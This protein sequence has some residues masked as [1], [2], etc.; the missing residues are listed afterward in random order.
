MTVGLQHYL[1]VAAV[2]FALGMFAVLTRRNAIA[3][4]MGIELILNSCNLNLVAFSRY[5]AVSIEGQVMAIFVIVL[6]AAE[7]AVALAII[8]AIYQEIRSIS[9]D[10][11]NHLKG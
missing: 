10:E 5:V 11:T 3:M 8:L 6:A 7:A 4:L 2:L 1:V 9:P